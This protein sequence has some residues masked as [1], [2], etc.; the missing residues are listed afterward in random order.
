MKL[1]YLLNLKVPSMAIVIII[2]TP[3][4]MKQYMGCCPVIEIGIRAESKLVK[5]LLIIVLFFKDE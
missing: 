2:I 1:A 4:A 5:L 3:L